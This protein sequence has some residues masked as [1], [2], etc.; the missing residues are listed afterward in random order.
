MDLRTERQTDGQTAL[1]DCFVDPTQ[2]SS[3]IPSVLSDSPSSTDDVYQRHLSYHNGQ[4]NHKCDFMQYMSLSYLIFTLSTFVVPFI[5]ITTGKY[6][7]SRVHWALLIRF[8]DPSDC[9]LITHSL[10]R[11]FRKGFA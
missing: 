4:M 7:F 2:A 6:A 1:K 11:V 10:F 9:W 3:L 8:I 5:L